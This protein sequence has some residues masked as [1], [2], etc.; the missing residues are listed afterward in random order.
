MYC[1]LFGFYIIHRQLKCFCVPPFQGCS[2]SDGMNPIVVV[3][4][5][6]GIEFIQTLIPLS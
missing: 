2:C 6:F 3:Y 5:P 1:F 4:H